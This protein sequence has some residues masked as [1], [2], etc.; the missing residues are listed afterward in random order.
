MRNRRDN[1]AL[2][3]LRVTKGGV[4]V[5]EGAR[6]NPGTVQNITPL[7][8]GLVRGRLVED[9][10]QFVPVL[11]SRIVGEKSRIRG[12]LGD[13]QRLDETDKKRVIAGGNVKNVTNTY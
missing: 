9:F 4:H 12:G 2:L 10:F 5:V 13:L 7:G 3:N 6:R 8:D 1:A 11:K